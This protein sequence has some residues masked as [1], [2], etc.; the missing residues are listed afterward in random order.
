MR[1]S[2]DLAD[3]AS[4]ANGIHNSITANSTA[5]TSIVVNGTTLDATSLGDY[6]NTSQL[7][8]N[9][10]NYAAIANPTFTGNVTTANISLTGAVSAN[11]S[12]G[13]DG[14]VLTSNGSSVYWSSAGFANGQSI[15]VNNFVINGSLSVNGAAGNTGQVLVSN[16][17]SVYWADQGTKLASI[18]EIETDINSNFT[19]PTNKYYAS[20][21]P[22][23]IASNVTVTVSSGATWRIIK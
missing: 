3:L 5:I 6:V 7:S 17:S 18:F 12:T 19:V 11:S 20:L 4:I 9:L 15:S 16:N 8:S 23:T 2:S 21:D 10:S 13:T 14:Q 22:I 1:F